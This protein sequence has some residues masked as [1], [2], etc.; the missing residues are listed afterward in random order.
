MVKAIL[1]P[2]NNRVHVD[3]PQQYIG[4]KL[5]VLLY[6]IDELIEQEK[7]PVTMKQFKGTLSKE[8]TEKLLEEVAKSREEWDT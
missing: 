6:P 3:I 8:D 1:T 5:E 4:R 2:D 7:Q